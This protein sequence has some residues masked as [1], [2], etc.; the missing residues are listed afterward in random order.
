M[1]VDHLNDTRKKRHVGEHVSGRALRTSDGGPSP[2]LFAVHAFE[3]ARRR[4]RPRRLSIISARLESAR[5][6]RAVARARGR[7]GMGNLAEA[8]GLCKV[9]VLRRVSERLHSGGGGTG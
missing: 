7:E 2:W 8:G 6:T 9:A 4:S 3:F 5:T 1:A